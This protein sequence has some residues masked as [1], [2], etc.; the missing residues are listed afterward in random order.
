MKEE[1]PYQFALDHISMNDWLMSE[2]DKLSDRLFAK[3]AKIREM[4]KNFEEP[5]E[6]DLDELQ[7]LYN[8]MTE[9]ENRMRFENKEYFKVMKKLDDMEF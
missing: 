1:D 2:A 4:E 5:T 7:V 9:L 6:E 3:E 8:H